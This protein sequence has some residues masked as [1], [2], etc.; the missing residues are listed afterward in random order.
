[1]LFE[2]GV[3]LLDKH[4]RPRNAMM[5]MAAD[6]VEFVDTWH[7]SGLS[8]SGSL[9]YQVQELFVPLEHVVGLKNDDP[10]PPTTLH[11]FPNFTFLTLGIGAVCMGVARASIDELV[12]LAVAKKRVG[13]R[14]S[15]SQ[16]QVSQIKLAQ[17]EADLQSARLFYYQALDS[18]WNSAL[19][20]QQVTLD[21]RRD[22][23]LATT[24]AVNKSVN[25]V[26]E[27][28]NL[29]GGSSV[30]QTSRLQRH[31]RDIN[32]AKT[33]IMVSQQV[34]EIVGALYFGLEPNV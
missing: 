23:R 26:Q 34:F 22:L 21:M 20:N 25:V 16:Q 2:H 18:A 5:L 30:Y 14:K 27:M 7:V 10:V 28:Y 12:S 31:F 6:D 32:V 13:A 17:A 4:G 3:P 11:T 9:D 24:N 1:M 15:V 19:E 29:G 33:H 8:G